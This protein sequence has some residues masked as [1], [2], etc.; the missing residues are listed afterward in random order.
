VDGEAIGLRAG[1]GREQ[2]A[3]ERLARLFDAHH[4]RLYRLARRLCGSIEEARDLVQETFLRVADRPGGIP[5][6]VQSEEAWLVRVLVNVARNEWRKQKGRRLLEQR[7][8]HE[9][10][11]AP[12]PLPDAATLARRTLWDAMRQLPPRRRAALILYELEG[13]TVTRIARLLGVSPI[14]VRWY[15]AQGRRDLARLIDPERTP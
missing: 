1:I 9:V 4:Q 5:A 2:T 14:T 11:V 15:L 3:D 13:A 12:P 10:T 6:D 8:L 7:H